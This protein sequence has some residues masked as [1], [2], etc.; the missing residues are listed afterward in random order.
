LLHLSRSLT[1][2]EAVLQS[3][4]PAARAVQAYEKAL[5][6]VAA[7]GGDAAAAEA[8]LD[9]ATDD[10]NACGSWALDAEARRS[11]ARNSGAPRPRCSNAPRWGAL[12]AGQECMPPPRVARPLWDLEDC[13]GLS[14][15]SRPL[16]V[17]MSWS[18]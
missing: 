2:L 6:L 9:K 16:Q 14:L 3:D 12:Q 18:A 8:R 11:G 10:M 17:L 15:K 7:G 5:A 1:I 13:E 4:S